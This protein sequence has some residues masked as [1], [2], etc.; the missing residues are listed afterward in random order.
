M[1]GL[2]YVLVYV[3]Q[4]VNF[5]AYSSLRIIYNTKYYSLHTIVVK[6][7]Q[8]AIF[9]RELQR[10]SYIMLV[11]QRQVSLNKTLS[12]GGQKGRSCARISNAPRQNI[13]FHSLDLFFSLL[14]SP[15]DGE[16]L[17]QIT[18]ILVYYSTRCSSTYTIT[19]IL[20]SR[21]S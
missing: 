17:L 14:L 19:D 3:L 21:K 7:K 10:L 12:S 8:P 15:D 16:W 18:T 5:L 6:R 20:Q 9:Y 1:P 2:N 13:N 4:H 11:Y